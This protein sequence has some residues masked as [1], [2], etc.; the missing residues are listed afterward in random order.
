L[1]VVANRKE[2]SADPQGFTRKKLGVAFAT[3][4]FAISDSRQ[5]QDKK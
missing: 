3:S 5:A 4:F 1:V 2:R